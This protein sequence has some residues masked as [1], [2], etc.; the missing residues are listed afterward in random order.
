[1]DGMFL[2]HF[3]YPRQFDHCR[4]A[5]GVTQHPARRS[6]DFPPQCPGLTGT[7]GGHPECLALSARKFSTQPSEGQRL[8]EVGVRSTD[9][10]LNFGLGRLR[11]PGE[12][13]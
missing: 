10:R 7:C 12:V 5:L 9:T 4:K 11:E 8:S 2:C 13:H 3:P 6:P 1:M